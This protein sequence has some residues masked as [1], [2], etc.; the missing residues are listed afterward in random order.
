MLEAIEQDQLQQN[1]HEVG[2]YLIDQLQTLQKVR[3]LPSNQQPTL[4]RTAD[5]AQAYVLMSGSMT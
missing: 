2:T 4:L 5:S 1:A 3:H